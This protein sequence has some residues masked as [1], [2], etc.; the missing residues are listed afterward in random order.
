LHF[1]HCE[2]ISLFLL[3]DHQDAL[4]NRSRTFAEGIVIMACPVL[5]AITFDKVDL[6]FEGNLF[7]RG[8]ISPIAAL[9]LEAGILPFLGLCLSKALADLSPGLSRYLFGASKLLI[10]LCALLL[11]ALAYG[12]LLLISMKNLLYLLFLIP[13]LALTM[14]RCFWSVQIGPM[15]D[16]ALYQGCEDKLEKSLDFSAAVTA[17]MFLG[18]EGLALEGHSNGAKGVERLLVASLGVSFITCVVGVFIMLL[19]TVPPLIDG[20][21]GESTSMCRVVEIL[22]G[23]LAIAFVFTVLLIASAT[24]KELVWLVFLPSLVPGMVWL[25]MICDDDGQAGRDEQV[26]PASME[27]TKVTFTGFL[28]ISVPTLSE[29]SLSNCTNA[30]VLLTAAAVVT[31]IGWRLL[32]HTAAPSRAM[33]RATNVASFCAHLCVAAAVIPFA[34]MAVNALK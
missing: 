1:A 17:I 27:L 31:G 15:I 10:H 30:F 19:G 22:N 28:A 13:F 32:T 9:T 8:S 21:N 6:K 25:F 24:L 12:I 2:I 23:V 7:I 4:K 26:K 5:L 11:M 34:T 20:N 29:R 16:D 14:R 18:L 3:S 33:D